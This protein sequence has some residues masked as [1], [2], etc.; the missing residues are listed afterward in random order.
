MGANQKNFFI[1]TYGC[2]MNEYD[3]RL[4]QSLLEKENAVK[5]K[6]VEE[7]D[8]ILLNTCA[9]RE[10]AVN[11]IFNRIQSLAY[12]KKNGAKIGVLGCVAQS[13]KDEIFQK[14]IPIDFIIGPDSLRNLPEI[15]NNP[16]KS[17][18]LELSKEELYED[19]IEEMKPPEDAYYNK[20]SAFVAIQRGCNNF[21]TF[22][23]VPYTRG[24][25][26]SRNPASII[27][28]IDK[29][30][31][32]G[33]KSVTLLGQNVNSYKY[34]DFDFCGLV[35]EILNKTKINRIYFTSPHPKDFPEKLI[36]LMANEPRFI[37][38]IHLP[39]QSGSNKILKQM[40]RN[41]TADVFLKLT[42]DIRNKVNDI[43]LSTDIIVGYPGEEHEDFLD[44]LEIMEKADF[45]SAFM[46]AYSER[47]YT[48]ASKK[49]KDNVSPE[50]K[51]N[52][53]TILI[54]RQQNRSLV[55]NKYHIGR[56]LSVLAESVSRKNE[57][58]LIGRDLSGRKTVFSVDNISENE[59]LEDKYGN[60]YKIKITGATSSTLLG[61]LEK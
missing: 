19:I 51:Q 10:N 5:T 57:K 22:C 37:S 23:I 46:F 15:L 60:I 39:L 53:L 1:E 18:H 17:K 40:K 11:K 52:R 55:K 59:S 49:H 44:T 27:H 38:Q 41:Y 48:F 12:L 2:Q 9:V 58:E 4:A 54:D 43:Y 20:L 56:T 14:N 36:D 50:E 47:K 6:T 13:V 42:E 16:Q 31:N 7:A 24:R 30:Y 33:I 28:E 21:C 25:E 29:L 45:D 3:S 34:D 8:I 32:A 26:R 35:A 61:I